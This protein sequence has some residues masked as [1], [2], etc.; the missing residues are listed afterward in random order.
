[1]RVL[2]RHR[3]VRL[4]VLGQS[5][6][7]LGDASLWLA[8][9]IWVKTLTGSAAAA[10]MVMFF[11]SLSALAAPIVGLVVDRLRR[12]PLIIWA[13]VTGPVLISPLLFVH[14]HAAVWVVYLVM[15]G[16]GL[17]NRVLSAAQ[18]ALLA[19]IVADQDLAGANGLIRSVQ[20]AM[21]IVVPL[22]GAGLFAWQGIAA[23]VGLD[24]A[25]F[26]GAV[27][28]FSA[29]RVAEPPPAPAESHW[30][31]ELTAG[32]RYVW[33]QR[34]LRAVVLGGTVAVLVFG[35]TESALFAVVTDGLHRPAS[36]IGVTG[37]AQGVGSLLVGPFIGRAAQ[38]I[39]EIRLVVLG[40][41]GYAASLLLL[42]VP[43]LPVV[44]S[45]LFIAGVSL[46]LVAVGSF[47]CLQRYSP[48]R[49]QGRVFSAADLLFSTGLV[50]S[51]AV[52]A[53]LLTLL[54]YPLL[55][56]VAVAVLIVSSVIVL[57]ARTGTGTEPVA[58]E[59]P[60]A[61]KVGVDADPA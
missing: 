28:I 40:L 36:F 20:E 38:R 59:V 7:S 16:Y 9:A 61:V 57:T 31:R 50:T 6:S 2:P 15:T 51:I 52:G 32:A 30:R 45:A 41:L 56:V 34:V 49:L 3:E 8:A 58:A 21:R 44:L 23:V 53:G 37:V 17:L 27:G 39:G 26:L 46:P 33:R 55:F 60:V 10:G 42:I 18:S 5:L 4:Y 43:A 11:F 1:M 54:G 29:M 22:L 14:G 25:T 12:L 24:I 47:T 48:N 13:N 35:F 19:T